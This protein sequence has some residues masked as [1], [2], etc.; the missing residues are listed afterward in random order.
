VSGIDAG[1]RALVGSGPRIYYLPGERVLCRLQGMVGQRL[2]LPAGDARVWWPRLSV[3]SDPGEHP[4]VLAIEGESRAEMLVE[5][6][7]RF[8]LSRPV[9]RAEIRRI[10]DARRLAEYELS[11]AL[12]ENRA[13]TGER[14]LVLTCAHR[15]E[16]P[17]CDWAARRRLWRADVSPGVRGP[18]VLDAGEGR[19]RAA[20]ERM[21]HT[22]AL[23]EK[24]R[25]LRVAAGLSR[26][27]LA[28]RCRISPSMLSK[29]ERE[30]SEPRLSL[31]LILCDGLDLSPNTLIGELPVPRS[32]DADEW[33]KTWT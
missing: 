26:W 29:T 3:R 4:L 21:R 28:G 17:Q 22:R 6:A 19:L 27:Q 1:V 11:Q 31:I 25:D 33:A 18:R 12:E 10:E 32:A 8:D 14:E 15:V 16:R 7:R 20:S 5:F 24:L 23:G 13:L 9:V 30:V 2:A